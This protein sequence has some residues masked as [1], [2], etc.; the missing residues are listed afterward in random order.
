MIAI[1]RTSFTKLPGRIVAVQAIA[2]NLYALNFTTRKFATPTFL[3]SALIK[4]GGQSAHAQRTNTRA[5]TAAAD[6]NSTQS[7]TA[8]VSSECEDGVLQ[9]S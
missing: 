1:S 9:G 4:C 3:A 2:F 5:V 8:A 7:S 6:F